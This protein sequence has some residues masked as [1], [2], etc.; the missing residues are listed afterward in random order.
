MDDQA[1]K[2]VAE[3]HEFLQ[4]WFNGSIGNDDQIYRRFAGVMAEGFQLISPGGMV[5]D[6]DAMLDGVRGAHG[7]ERDARLPMK[8]WIQNHRG[9]V[10]A[11]GLH[12]VTY[13][14]WQE[15]GGVTRGRVSTALFARREGTPNGVEWLHV[16][17]V[18]MP[19]GTSVD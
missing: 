13:E 11:D 2:E 7:R 3:I 6:R 19:A 5:T 15:K 14:E 17:E 12:L 8:I 16:H 1:R 18:W 4:D 10:L 9:R